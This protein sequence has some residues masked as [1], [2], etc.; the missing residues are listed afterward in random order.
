MST[1]SLVFQIYEPY[2]TWITIGKLI[3]KCKIT[4]EIFLGKNFRIARKIL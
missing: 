1:E 2:Q 3:S 4:F